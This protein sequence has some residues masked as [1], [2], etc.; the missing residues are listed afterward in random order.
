MSGVVIDADQHLALAPAHEVGHVLLLVKGEIDATAGG[1]PIRR[2]HL[3]ERARSFI[4]FG[5]REPGQVLDVGA[6]NALP[7]GGQLLLDAQQ[8]DG[9]PCSGGTE[10]LP[11]DLAT[12][13]MLLQVKEP[14]GALVIGEGLGA[15]HLLPLEDLARTERPFELAH[16]FYQVVLH[17]TVEGDQV[18]VEI[19]QHLHEC[20][21]KRGIKR[22]ARRRLP[23]I[24]GMTGEV[25]GI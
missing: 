11:G 1:L 22:S 14:G 13:G 3:E 6:G 16:E 2:V 18:T 23:L 19:I 15:R 9:R 7:R 25:I 8:V 17:N 4:A 10:R 21:G 5:A 20:G 12:E 24:Q